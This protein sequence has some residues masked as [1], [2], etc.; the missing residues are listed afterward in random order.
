MLLNWKE[1]DGAL[2]LCCNFLFFKASL[3]H[4]RS[5][6]S[7]S[8]QAA[9]WMGSIPAL[10]CTLA[11]SGY[12]SRISRNASNFTLFAAAQCRGVI[13][14]TSACLASLLL[15]RI[16][17]WISSLDLPSW[18]HRC[19]S[20]HS[21]RSQSFVFLDRNRFH[22][23][24]VPFSPP[25]A[26]PSC[27]QRGA[28][29]RDVDRFCRR[30]HL[31]SDLGFPTPPDRKTEGFEPGIRRVQTR[32]PS[33]SNPDSRRPRPRRRDGGSP[34]RDRNPNGET[35]GYLRGGGEGGRIARRGSSQAIDVRHAGTVPTPSSRSWLAIARHWKACMCRKRP[36]PPL[37]TVRAPFQVPPAT[38]KGRRRA[39]IDVR[40]NRSASS[41]LSGKGTP[42]LK[43][44][45]MTPLPE[46]RGTPIPVFPL[47]PP[48][49]PCDQKI[50]ISSPIHPG[51]VSIPRVSF[52]GKRSRSSRDVSI[53][54]GP[55][56]WRPTL[57]F[58]GRKRSTRSSKARSLR[59]ALLALTSSGVRSDP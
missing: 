47:F 39:R 44:P 22:H 55:G 1:V 15:L 14:L 37:Q 56:S 13:P 40:P 23:L 7:V 4:S 17:L 27:V 3:V 30:D 54:S 53:L 29:A 45:F 26:F 33:G 12:A 28:R 50:S 42:L 10:S 38:G 41:R 43:E 49:P 57:A 20:V 31:V 21:S 58:K 5:I 34:R 2:H 18:R 9:Q 35:N 36:K 59:D 51:I 8:P 25:M 11:A 16:T 19:S 24:F 52:L 48:I 46:V 32:K 6:F